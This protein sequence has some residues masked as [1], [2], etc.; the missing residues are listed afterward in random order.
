M[1][2]RI[3]WF[4]AAAVA[5]IGG[6]IWQDGGKFLSWD[7][8][9][10]TVDAQRVI[11]RGVEKMQVTDSQGREIDVPPETKRAFAEAIGRLVKAETDFAL[12]R[13]GDASAEELQAAGA[14]RN[15]VRADVD[16]LKAEIQRHE[17]AAA[18]LDRD[19]LREQIQSEV[20]AEV[21]T[22]VRK[23]VGN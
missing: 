7:D 19:A 6:I 2:S 10:V 17:P 11:D 21:R 12:L 8:H 20:R 15:Q 23:A 5:L 16:R 18:L 1:A 3:M 13:A 9:G 4:F 14:R 22:S